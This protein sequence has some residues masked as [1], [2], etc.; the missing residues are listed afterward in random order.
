MLIRFAAEKMLEDFCTGPVEIIYQK[1]QKLS[2]MNEYFLLM[3]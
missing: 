1:H 2:I 3:E